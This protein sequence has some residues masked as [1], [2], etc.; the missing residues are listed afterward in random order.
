MRESGFKSP[1]PCCRLWG[2]LRTA[3]PPLGGW[4]RCRRQRRAQL[5]RRGPPQRVAG[6]GAPFCGG[7]GGGAPGVCWVPG[8]LPTATLLAAASHNSC[9]ETHLRFRFSCLAQTISGRGGVKIEVEE[10]G[11][12]AFSFLGEKHHWATWG[13]FPDLRHLNKLKAC[14][15]QERHGRQILG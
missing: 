2:V 4:I 7:S 3:G 6:R 5:R 8:C 1:G 15:R 10:V 11:L 12:S 13:P 9:R 14:L